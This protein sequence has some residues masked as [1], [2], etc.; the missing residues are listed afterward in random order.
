MEAGRIF[1]YSSL[2]LSIMLERSRHLYPD[3]VKYR[4]TVP[5]TSIA[6][7]PNGPTTHLEGCTENR[8]HWLHHSMAMSQMTVQTNFFPISLM[9]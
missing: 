6:P 1:F 5:G 2:K 8:A 9:D 7:V 4:R 3:Y